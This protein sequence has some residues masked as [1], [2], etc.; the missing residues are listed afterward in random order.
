MNL[1]LEIYNFGL[2]A[3]ITNWLRED[4]HASIL[5]WQDQGHKITA[6]PKVNA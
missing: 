3:G 1:E 6:K 2:E 4:L 5:K